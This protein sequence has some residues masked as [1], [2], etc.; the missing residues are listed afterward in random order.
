MTNEQ[1]TEETWREVGGQFQALG[2]SLAQAFRTAW[3][4]EENRQHLRDMRDDLEAMVDNVGQAIKE[5]SV[6]PGG[7]KVRREA[8]KTAAS[9]RAAGEQALQ[10]ARP[11]LLSA[12]RQI[13]TELQKMIGHMEEKQPA[14][15][16]A[17]AEFAPEE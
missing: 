6:S 7:Q 14:S 1:M 15:E 13:N 10:K 4:N 5:A 3:E 11:H 2:E 9:A 8:Q 12:L 17:A 16:D